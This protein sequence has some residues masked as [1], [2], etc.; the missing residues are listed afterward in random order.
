MNLPQLHTLASVF[1][2]SLLVVAAPLWSRGEDAPPVI[3]RE[4][5]GIPRGVLKGHTD[6]VRCVAISKDGLIAS[7]SI[8]NTARLWDSATRRQLFVLHTSDAVA[9]L[10]FSGDGKILATGGPDARVVLWDTA[11]GKETK[12]L[13]GMTAA[14][15]K[16]GLSDDG[17]VVAAAGGQDGKIWDA[18]TGKV[19]LSFEGKFALSPDGHVLATS[20]T[21][22][23]LLTD[24][25]T[26]KE[27]HLEG[28][29]GYANEL[30]FSPDGK[31]LASG[32]ASVRGIRG[33]PTDPRQDKLV[34]LWD[35]ESGKNTATLE[36][37]ANGIGHLMFAPDGKTLVSTD[38]NG[39]MR[40]WDLST[41]KTTATLENVKYVDG[42]A[43]T[44]LG[45]WALAPNL[46]NWAVGTGDEI[47]LIDITDFTG[48]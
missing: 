24:V 15:F 37:H 42:T 40:L 33:D 35:V 43:R 32:G 36:G 19:L 41:M 47:I 13:T 26:G 31:T 28:H 48:K 39:C 44:P 23:I 46:K 1:I 20:L 3:P 29:L 27:R 14:I 16:L 6:A 45:F 18:E 9:E 5:P 25:L 30:R 34:K 22:G 4:H 11:T 38:Y 17:K 12:R 21:H 10:C 7:G 8:D 2:F